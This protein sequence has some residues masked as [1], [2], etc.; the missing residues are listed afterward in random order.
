MRRRAFLAG[1]GA[2]GVGVGCNVPTGAEPPGPTEPTAPS[3]ADLVTGDAGMSL[4]ELDQ[5]HLDAALSEAGGVAPEVGTTTYQDW[6]GNYDLRKTIR[7][8]RVLPKIGSRELAPRIAPDAE[9]AD[10]AHLVEHPA[11][12]GTFTLRPEGLE[13][14]CASNH[15]A[16]TFGKPL[17][18]QSVAQDIVIFGLRGC[19]VPKADRTEAWKP[20]KAVVLQETAFDHLSMSCTIGVWNRTDGTVMALAGSTVPHLSYMQLHRIHRHLLDERKLEDATFGPDDVIS[21]DMKTRA[22]FYGWKANQLGQG[23]HLMTIGTHVTGSTNVYRVP[24]Q[25]KHW[26]GP[27]LRA[28]GGPGYTF[29]DWDPSSRVV[30][31][32]IHPAWSGRPGTSGVYVDF[33]SAGCTTV[34]GG[35]SGDRPFR[36]YIAAL[37]HYLNRGGVERKNGDNYLYLL[38]SGREAR[39]H[40]NGTALDRWRFG[41]SGEHVKAIQEAVGAEPTGL[42]DWQTHYAVRTWQEADNLPTDGVVTPERFPT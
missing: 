34:S 20:A 25:S 24:K 7:D 38:T 40:A 16:A 39:L 37:V 31:D 9:S 8:Q 30:N 36:G 10:Y 33:A 5:L 41:A 11:S 42:F 27:V 28:E 21:D 6:R 1:V 18:G 3:L 26:F 17:G 23:L 12:D 13:S 2:V 19:T 32:N 15:Y 22:R 35:G 14:L 29:R 4:D